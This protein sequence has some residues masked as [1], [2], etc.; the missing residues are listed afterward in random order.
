MKKAIRYVIMFFIGGLSAFIAGEAGLTRTERGEMRVW[1]FVILI[2]VLI[3]GGGWLDRRYLKKCI[4][5]D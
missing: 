2:L 3:Y 4:G 1:A 5:E